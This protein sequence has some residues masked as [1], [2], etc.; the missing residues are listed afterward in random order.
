MLGT[1]YP[2][3]SLV[4]PHVG[5]DDRTE[6]TSHGLQ[7]RAVLQTRGYLCLHELLV[8][9]A[10]HGCHRRLT[11]VEK[12]N[13]SSVICQHALRLAQDEGENLVQFQGGAHSAGNLTQGIGVLAG[14]LLGLV[15]PCILDS[16]CGVAGEGFELLGIG[17]AE[18]ARTGTDHA[19]EAYRPAL[20]SDRCSNI[21]TPPLL[22][23]Q[24]N[25]IGI[26]GC[27]RDNHRFPTLHHLHQVGILS[28]RDG[29]MGKLF[30]R[31]QMIVPTP[32]D[33]PSIVS[34]DQHDVESIPLDDL[35]HLLQD[36][37]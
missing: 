10:K 14:N 4:P 2:Y 16:G 37:V 5:D 8:L 34:F 22:T 36:A 26:R 17:G 29:E 33:Q 35:L 15:Q 9:I 18:L 28:D 11:S 24:W 31:T 23:I 27:I 32:A 13:G 21:G 7:D 12:Q 6:V 1:R 20:H 30:I 25:P 3:P 19:Q